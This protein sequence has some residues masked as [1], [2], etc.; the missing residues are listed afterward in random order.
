MIAK[1]T[2]HGASALLV[3][4]ALMVIGVTAAG[5]P[6]SL[7]PCAHGLQTKGGYRPRV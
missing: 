5:D 6:M 1:Y 2:H 4:S 3:P 7:L